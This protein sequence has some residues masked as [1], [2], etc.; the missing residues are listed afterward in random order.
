MQRD[1]RG[2]VLGAYVH[3][4]HV[5]GEQGQAQAATPGKIYSSS[6]RASRHALTASD[7]LSDCDMPGQ[8][9]VAKSADGRGEHRG[10]R[11]RWARWVARAQHAA[12]HAARDAVEW[13]GAG[14]APSGA[15][16][17]RRTCGDGRCP[18]LA[19]ALL[20]CSAA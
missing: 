20:A 15:S 8:S 16:S 2:P 14:G 1:N 18:P 7:I 9:C 12:A 19:W 11:A 4:R 5:V 17:S 6:S 3:G 13:A 10:G